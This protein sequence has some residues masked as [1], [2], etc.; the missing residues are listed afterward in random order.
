MGNSDILILCGK[1]NIFIMRYTSG[2]HHTGVMCIHDSTI[3]TLSV[4]SSLIDTE[5]ST[6]GSLMTF[7][8]LFLSL[9]RGLFAIYML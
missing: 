9:V 3:R 1:D 2:C 4:I 8:Y 6:A 7:L 5:N